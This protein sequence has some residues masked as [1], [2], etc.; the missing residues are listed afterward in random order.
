MFAMFVRFNGTICYLN[1]IS[2]C[3]IVIVIKSS[4]HGTICLLLD[5]LDASCETYL[6]RENKQLLNQCYMLLLRTI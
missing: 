3:I 1:V 5:M 4:T 2:E 6:V